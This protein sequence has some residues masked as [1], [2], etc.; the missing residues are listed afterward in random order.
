MRG[1]IIKRVWRSRGPTGHK[2][3]HVAYGYSLWVNGHR[4]RRVDSAWI[5]DDAEKA[6]AE[7]ILGLEQEE[8]KRARGMTFGEAIE[9]Y[10]QTK[11]RKKSLA[12]D[13]LYLKAFITAWGA[14][15]PLKEITAD[16]ISAW[17]AEKLAAVCAR[18]KQPL[19]PASINRPLSA[20]R[21]LLNLAHEEW[22]ALAAVPRIR[23]EQEPEGR[24]RWLELQEEARLLAE[25]AR[26]K[27]PEL[28]A[29]VTVD[30]ETGLRK[31]ELLGLT[32]ERV[33]LSRSVL[34]L[35]QTKGGKR[36]E[37]PMR[38]AVY[39]LFATWPGPRKGRVFKTRKLRTAFENAVERAGLEDFHF[40]DCRHHFASWFVMRGGRIEALQKILGHKTLSMTLRYAHLAP[41]YLRAEME[42]TERPSTGT[43]VAQSV[44]DVLSSE[45]R[46]SAGAAGS[47]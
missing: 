46:V 28:F 26:S 43:K 10:F 17:K 29:L 38:Q 32:W 23:Q 39:D 18:T 12:F 1:K 11:A 35:E 9:R 34:M 14:E 6:L 2:V 33:D 30:L 45:E 5:K 40:H 13:R 20:L 37:V 16:R 47:A 24:I 27:N 7:R 41:E 42:R 19:A 25:C 31:G 22:G 3:K 4:K 8:A 15:T 44:P 36:R 21:H